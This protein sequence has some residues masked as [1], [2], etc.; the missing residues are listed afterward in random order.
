MSLLTHPSFTVV[1]MHGPFL[2]V[3][4]GSLAFN[5]WAQT[6]A[7]SALV[8]GLQQVGRLGGWVGLGH[9]LHRRRVPTASVSFP[10]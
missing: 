4:Q 5:P 6:P 2:S 10:H 8:I 9:G 7:L 3:S 1:N